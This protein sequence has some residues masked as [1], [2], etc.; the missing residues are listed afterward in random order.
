MLNPIPPHLSRSRVI[1]LYVIR[2]RKS[3]KFHPEFTPLFMITVGAD[4]LLFLISPYRLATTGNDFTAVVF[5]FVA[6]ESIEVGPIAW[7]PSQYASSTWILRE[8]IPSSLHQQFLDFFGCSNPKGDNR[9]SL[10][11]HRFLN[12][13]CMMILPNKR[14]ITSPPLTVLAS[15]IVVLHSLVSII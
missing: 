9:T 10:R 2:N 11:F 6:I 4:W 15:I 3:G 13:T 8:S 1:L 12:H 14:S 5:F 7:C